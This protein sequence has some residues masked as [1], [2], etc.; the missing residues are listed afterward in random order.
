MQRL[1]LML[2]AAVL[3]LLVAG[4]VL[5]QQQRL[6][7]TDETGNLDRG[8]LEDA[9]EPLIDRGAVVAIYMVNQ[10]GDTDF[11]QRLRADNLLSSDGRLRQGLIAIYVSTNPRR[12]NMRF[13]DSWNEALAV[14]NNYQAILQSDLAPG[15]SAGNFTAGFVDALEAVD[16][17]IENP[18]V[19]GGG[20]SF[21][22]ST[23]PLVIGGFAMLF[24][25]VGGFLFVSRRS[26]AQALERSRTLAEEARQAAG[27]AIVEAERLL[28]TALEKAQFDRLS[29]DPEDVQ[30]LAEQQ[31]QVEAQFTR[32]KQQFDE[33]ENELNRREQPN[34]EHYDSTTQ[35][36]R[37]V[38]QATASVHEQLEQLAAQR[39][40]LDQLA[41][42]A[43]EELERTKKA[44]TGV[45]EALAPL[46]NE[47]P[48]TASVLAPIQQQLE[49]AGQALSENRA[50][51][52]LAEGQ[53]ASGLVQSVSALLATYAAIRAGITQAQN[54]AERLAAEGYR[55]DTSRA[56]LDQSQA[57]LTEAARGLQRRGKDFP[58]AASAA[59]ERAQTAL[60]AAVASGRELPNLRT[61]NERRLT[62][63]EALGSQVAQAIIEGRKTFVLVNEFAESTWDDIRG[64]GSEAQASADRA[65]QHWLKAR[66]RNSMDVQE[67][68]AAS[69]ALDAASQELDYAR[70]LIDAITQRLRDLQAARDA[71]RT[72]LSDAA[73]DIE[74]GWA[75]IRQNDEDI[76]KEPEQ[77]L[78]RAAELL[79]AAEQEMKKDKPDWLLLVEQAQTANRLADEALAGARSEFETMDKLRKQAERAQQVTTAEVQKIIK[80]VELHG[81]DIESKNQQATAGLQQRAQQA[82]TLMQR[83]EQTEEGERRKALEQALNNYTGIGQ[84]A[85][86]VYQAVQADFRQLE[87]V[88]AELNSELSNARRTIEAAEQEL[89]A[90]HL[91]SSSSEGR[92]LRDIRQRFDK[93][94]LPIRGERNLRRTL[95][96]ARSLQHDANDVRNDIHRHHRPTHHHRHGG[97]GDVGDFVAGVALGALLDAATRSG[98]WGGSGSWSGGEGGGEGG[99]GI[100]WGGG[101]GG[102]VD[103]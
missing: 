101:G 36:Y 38:Q 14:N 41:D 96:L 63:L 74:R 65:H 19:P 24:L 80:F 29:Y 62:E 59:L 32:V 3:A 85:A 102:G 51:R 103:W 40:E 66:Q 16:S 30:R 42:Q 54:D 34:I 35:A 52:A 75:F 84:E 20:T 39:R 25:L 100:D 48:D 33:I 79:A 27:V 91:S 95:D 68:A 22:V 21:N 10:G 26:A 57:A 1:M 72:E 15:L 6:Y 76:G 78:H 4:P 47:I 67:F 56:A 58:A 69:E 49:R 55:M 31:K 7:V 18:P 97:G 50:R 11:E 44:L 23:L 81:E 9:A 90:Y 53:A 46:Q 60:N 82:A 2:A 28:Q 86:Q 73:Q 93:I 99:G 77:K 5:A 13:E 87:Q 12:A 71:A 98:G 89:L 94:R 37:E 64:N 43:Q 88:R 17:A 83:A 92:A 70:K 45:A 61:A 8:A